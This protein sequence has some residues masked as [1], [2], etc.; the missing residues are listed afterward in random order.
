VESS[1][2]FGI[3]P[4]GSIKLYIQCVVLMGAVIPPDGPTVESRNIYFCSL[5]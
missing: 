5:K 4:S 2:E 3:E 1:C